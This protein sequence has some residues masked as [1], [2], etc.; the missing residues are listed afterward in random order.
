MKYKPGFSDAKRFNRQ[1]L[2]STGVGHFL[3]SSRE[4]EQMEDLIILNDVGIPSK[5]LAATDKA[6]REGKAKSRNDLIA[7][8]LRREIEAIKRAEIDAQLACMVNDADYQEEVL[9]M[10]AEFATPQWEAFKLAESEQ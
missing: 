3:Q 9:Q 1:L 4:V 10:E 6:V 2:K 7:K 5:L 8:A